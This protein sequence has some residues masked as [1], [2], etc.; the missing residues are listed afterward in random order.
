MCSAGQFLVWSLSICT[1]PL[2]A[3]VK[4][5]QGSSLYVRTGGRVSGLSSRCLGGLELVELLFDGGYVRSRFAQRR[6]NF[7]IEL[8]QRNFQ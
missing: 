3:R 4:Q 1:A 6:R 5:K 2:L 8:L 7:S